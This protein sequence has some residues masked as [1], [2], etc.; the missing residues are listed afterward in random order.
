M[1]EKGYYLTG[2]EVHEI[3]GTEALKSG[4]TPLGGSNFSG[5]ENVTEKY[6]VDEALLSDYE[7]QEFV[8]FEHVQKKKGKYYN[9]FEHDLPEPDWNWINT[10]TVGPAQCVRTPEGY[11]VLAVAAG[12]ARNGTCKIYDKDKQ[13]IKTAGTLN[14]QMRYSSFIV[15]DFAINGVNYGNCAMFKYWS[16]G[17]N[18]VT[19]IDEP[20][21]DSQIVNGNT[22]Y[23]WTN[24]GD[25]VTTQ[26]QNI[27]QYM[28]SFYDS[29]SNKIKDYTAENVASNY[30][31]RIVSYC[32]SK[33]FICII[34]SEN[35]QMCYVYD[36]HRMEAEDIM[37]LQHNYGWKTHPALVRQFS[38]PESE[39]HGKCITLYGNI[40]F[41]TLGVGSNIYAFDINTGTKL[42]S[43][44]FGHYN[45]GFLRWRNKIA[46]FGE[47]TGDKS[48]LEFNPETNTFR[49][50]L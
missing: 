35:M 23:L 5:K 24:F 32:F 12:G 36:L 11:Y 45:F 7:D 33:D 43:Y 31:L 8:I 1:K 39:N 29:H 19:H 34:F 6:N 41:S 22:V 9:G 14:Q 42:A 50:I 26:E 17:L 4:H 3:L 48:F 2:E 13:L 47:D 30:K 27:I 20:D 18:V 40:L 15:Q 25:N 37:G 21:V 38:I 16:H 46:I 49:R 44:N 10:Q 28:E